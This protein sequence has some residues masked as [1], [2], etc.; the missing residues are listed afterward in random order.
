MFQALWMMSKKPYD[1]S[2]RRL[3]QKSSGPSLPTEDRK[4]QNVL[5]LVTVEHRSFVSGKD[6]FLR[7]GV[8]TKTRS[9]LAAMCP[10]P[11]LLLFQVKLP[12]L[13][14][15]SN[16]PQIETKSSNL[17]P[18]GSL[19]LEPPLHSSFDMVMLKSLAIMRGICFFPTHWS[20][21]EFQKTSLWACMVGP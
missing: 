10:S 20:S 18:K 19:S 17:Y 13:G 16:K 3:K 2:Q 7:K 4:R 1:S 5:W 21:S 8:L 15:I 9:N 11:S 14:L 12:L 6:I